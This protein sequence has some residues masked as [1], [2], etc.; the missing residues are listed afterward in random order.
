[1]TGKQ[2]LQ[3]FT[4]IKTGVIKGEFWTDILQKNR[5]WPFTKVIEHFIMNT[6]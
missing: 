2:M 3:L 1:M 6:Q 4:Q 5:M